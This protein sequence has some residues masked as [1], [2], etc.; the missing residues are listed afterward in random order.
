MKTAEKA[1]KTAV[2]YS[3]QSYGEV[4]NSLSIEQQIERCIA[5]CKR[6][7]V[8]IKGI[9]KDCN[10]SSELYPSSKQGIEACAADMGWNRWLKRER[11]FKNRKQYRKGLA[12]AFTAIE[13]Q[14]IDFF[15]VD[16]VTRF[17]RNPWAT[18]QLDIFC[19]EHLVQ[20]GTA[21]VTVADGKIDKLENSVDIAIRRALQAFESSTL[22]EKAANSKKNR[23]ANINRGIVFSNAYGVDWINKKIHFNEKKAE[24]IRYVFEAVIKGKT[25]GEIL[26]TLNT[27]FISLAN[28][29]GFYETSIY[30]LI[31]NPIY[32]GYKRLQDGKYIEVQNMDNS[33]LISFTMFQKANEVVKS[34]KDASGKQ[35]YNVK[36]AD[37]RHF[38]PFSGLLRCGNCEKRLTVAFDRGIVYLCNNVH[39]K[40]DKRCTPSRIRFDWDMDSD[41]FLLVFQPLFLIKLQADIYEYR[42]IANTNREIETLQA[43]IVNL[44]SKMQTITEAFLSSSVEDVIFK[45]TIE[46]CKQEIVEKENKILTLVSFADKESDKEIQKLNHLTD[47]IQNSERLIPNDDYSRLLRETVKEVIIYEGYIKVILFDGNSFKLPRLKANRRSKKLPNAESYS[48]FIYEDENDKNKGGYLFPIIKF[49]CGGN[50]EETL[51][52]TAEYRIVIA[53]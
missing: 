33:P 6:N 17:Y 5:W 1:V 47:M 53:K 40:H 39:L 9:F 30:N 38:L 51:L 35:K 43:E 21:L 45:F 44:K 34:K 12:D 3:R 27:S 46:K 26:Y 36:N 2:I 8:E 22:M 16:E 4:N 14:H 23:R 42:Q 13:Q 31:S 32:C 18:A 10:T 15:V 28:G 48:K 25:Y 52:E 11:I 37:R 41:D 24:V 49:D 50:K 7:N 19:I 29:K 20:H